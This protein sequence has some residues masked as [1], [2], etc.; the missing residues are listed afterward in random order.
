MN[1]KLTF[2]QIQDFFGNRGIVILRG[3]FKK[4]GNCSNYIYWIP[5]NN[6]CSSELMSEG[7]GDMVLWT[8]LRSSYVEIEDEAPLNASPF[9]FKVRTVIK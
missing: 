2:K 9:D 1:N 6:R 3:H 4:W 8:S 5:N 7:E